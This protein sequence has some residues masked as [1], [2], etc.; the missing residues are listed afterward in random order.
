MDF[1][2]IKSF[3]RSMA[4]FDQPPEQSEAERSGNAENGSRSLPVSTQNSL[5]LD[6]N[7]SGPMNGAG[8]PK[9]R[10]VSESAGRDSGPI[11]SSVF[12]EEPGKTS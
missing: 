12:D 6:E 3:V 7:D 5:V 9:L 4:S 11:S 10:S 1:G 2:K 8:G